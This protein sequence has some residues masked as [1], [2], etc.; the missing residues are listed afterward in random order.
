VL[1]ATWNVQW[2]ARTHRDEITA[3]IATLDADVDPHSRGG[4][5]DPSNL[6]TACWACN[7]GKSSYTL[8]EL[9]MED[10]RRRVPALTAWNGLLDRS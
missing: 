6:V 7:Y 9:G 2:A 8:T 4:R 3:R 10:P 5:T 1:V